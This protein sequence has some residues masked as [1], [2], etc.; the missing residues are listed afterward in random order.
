MLTTPLRQYSNYGGCE[1]FHRTMKLIVVMAST[2]SNLGKKRKIRNNAV[3][4]LF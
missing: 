1:I 3:Q 2:N 4:C